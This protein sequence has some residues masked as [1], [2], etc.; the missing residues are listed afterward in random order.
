M[1]DVATKS[2]NKKVLK[3]DENSRNVKWII[4]LSE[5]KTKEMLNELTQVLKN[6]NTVKYLSY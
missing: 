5:K 3:S 6:W 1:A 4:V 2:N